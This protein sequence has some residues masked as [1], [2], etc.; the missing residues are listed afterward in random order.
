MF[1]LIYMLFINIQIYFSFPVIK[2]ILSGQMENMDQPW[3]FLNIPSV[4]RHDKVSN[5]SNIFKDPAFKPLQFSFYL[6]SRKFSSC[7]FSNNL[8]DDPTFP[9][10][11]PA[12]DP[13]VLNFP[14]RLKIRCSQGNTV[15]YKIIHFREYIAFQLANHPRDKLFQLFLMINVIFFRG[16]KVYLLGVPASGQERSLVSITNR[17]A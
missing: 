17:S 7:H 8:S 14:P 13:F 1:Q 12:I 11:D 15:M 9:F 5:I 16:F 3:F 10:W 2:N 6:I 4:G